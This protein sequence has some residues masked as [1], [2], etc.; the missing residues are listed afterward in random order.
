MRCS[1]FVRTVER[2]FPP[3]TMAVVL[4]LSANSLSRATVE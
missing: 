1:L 2:Q 3:R 4:D